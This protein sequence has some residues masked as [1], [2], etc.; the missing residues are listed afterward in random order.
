MN[1]FRQVSVKCEKQDLEGLYDIRD[2]GEIDTNL[3]E[4]REKDEVS[5]VLVNIFAMIQEL[6]LQYHQFIVAFSHKAN[7]RTVNGRRA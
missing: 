7:A 3:D 6:I 1:L 2:L 5:V 4:F